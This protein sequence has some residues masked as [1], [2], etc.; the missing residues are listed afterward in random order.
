MQKDACYVLSFSPHAPFGPMRCGTF[1]GTPIILVSCAEPS[2]G[3]GCR[4][5]VRNS[6]RFVMLELLAL[7]HL[8]PESLKEKRPPFQGA[9]TFWNLCS[10][11]RTY[12]VWKAEHMG[13]S[14]FVSLIPGARVATVTT[15]PNLAHLSRN[16]RPTYMRTL[17]LCDV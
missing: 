17:I 6:L 11:G 5:H 16:A 9:P 12:S 14:A 4:H 1:E 2:A 13:I 7:M 10:S 15:I 3:C 8:S